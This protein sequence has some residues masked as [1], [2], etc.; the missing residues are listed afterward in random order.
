MKNLMKDNI[1]RNFDAH[2]SGL[3]TILVLLFG[4]LLL[5]GCSGPEESSRELTAEESAALEQR[6]RD[7]WAAM[8]DHDF[9]RVYDFTTPNYRRIFTKD[10]FVNKFSY[11]VDWELTGVEVIN[12]DSRAAVASVVARVMTRST[13]LTEYAASGFGVVPRDLREQWIFIDGEWWYSANQ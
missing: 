3:R 6:V 8:A 7:R 10:M 1:L 2:T 12:Y 9:A 5:A 13:K 4:M 11:A